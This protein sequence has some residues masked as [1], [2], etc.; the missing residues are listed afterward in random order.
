MAKSLGK[1]WEEILFLI[2]QT[3]C[4]F[5]DRTRVTH[6]IDGPGDWQVAK[7]VVEDGV[8]LSFCW[9]SMKRFE[10]S[11]NISNGKDTTFL[12]ISGSQYENG[13]DNIPIIIIKGIAYEPIEEG[14]IRYKC[15]MAFN[16]HRIRESVLF[17]TQL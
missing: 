8:H 6:F 2:L 12:R 11:F 15:T 9:V 17:L 4:F 14:S 7:F 1:K 13:S 3:N 5:I 10:R 16:L